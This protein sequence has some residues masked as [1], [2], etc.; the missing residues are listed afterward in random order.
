MK[1]P[2]G[3]EMKA[4]TLTGS[5]IRVSVAGVVI[6]VSVT[7]AFVWSKV[8]LADIARRTSAAQLRFESLSEE[9]SRLTA[10]AIMQTKPGTIM[11]IARDRLGM[12]KAANH[13]LD[14]GLARAGG[15]GG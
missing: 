3:R 5:S 1:S 8:A 6:L 7:T 4:K 12:V 2:D 14:T 9:R 11:G 10:T 15:T 13:R